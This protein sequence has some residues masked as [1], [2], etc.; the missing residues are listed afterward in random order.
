MDP[1]LRTANKVQPPFKLNHFPKH[2][3]L[4]VAKDLILARFVRDTDSFEGADWERSFAKAI[5]ADWRPSN[6]GLDDV[7]LGNCCW[8]AKTVKNAHPDSVKRI[9]LITGRN[10]VNFSFD[11][12]NV[13]AIPPNELGEKVLEIWNSRVSSV[14]TRFAHVRTVV[15]VKG[16]ELLTGAIFEF[17]TLRT[18]SDQVSW[19][20]NKAGNLVGFTA[21]THRYTWQPHG[22]QFTMVHDV[23]KT[24]HFFRLNIP[25]ETERLNEQ[26]LLDSIG[27][28]DSWVEI[29]TTET[30]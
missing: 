20:W 15:L 11:I 4:S 3:I 9:R 2:V 1:K 26:T 29:A 8:G 5:G 23:P 18:E 19:E 12:P 10:S 27:Y 16:P 13:K 24:R 22:A 21:G 7:V 6:V 30:D 14:R 25:V 28:S 17:E